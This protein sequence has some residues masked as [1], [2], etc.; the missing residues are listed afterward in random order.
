[1]T[2]QLKTTRHNFG[3][4]VL[5]AQ[6]QKHYLPSL[7]WCS[8][9]W[10]HFLQQM[11]EESPEYLCKTFCTTQLRT[12]ITDSQHVS[13]IECP[14]T[15][16]HYCSWDCNVN[17]KSLLVK[18]TGLEIHLKEIFSTCSNQCDADCPCSR[19]EWSGTLVGHSKTSSGGESWSLGSLRLCG[20]QQEFQM[21]RPA[22]NQ[23]S[24]SV[25]LCRIIETY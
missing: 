24:L 14:F 16:F 19:G 6:Q 8:P 10:L 25:H 17:E 21:D 11:M 13:Q 5:T 18:H 22:S 9:S 4:T 1:M 20:F 2:R 3:Y 12:E 23:E 15:L 7:L